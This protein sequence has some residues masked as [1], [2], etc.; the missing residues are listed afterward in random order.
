[1]ALLQTLRAHAS[2]P[3]DDSDDEEKRRP[4]ILLAFQ[5]RHPQEEAQLLGPLARSFGCSRVVDLPVAGLPEVTP[6]E[7]AHMR[8]VELFFSASA[9][10]SA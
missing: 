8:I 1:M 6:W 9:H 4:R 10:A 7:E 3:L 5:S 2:N